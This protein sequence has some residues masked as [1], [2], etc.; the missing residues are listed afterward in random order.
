MKIAQLIQ[1]LARTTFYALFLCC[2]GTSPGQ[3]TVIFHNTGGGQPLISEVRSIFV[4]QGL[5]QPR[6][7]FDFGFGTDEVP[8]AG[9]FLDS[10]TVSLQDAA[11]R[12]SAIYLNADANG[13]SWAP[14]TPG[15]LFIDPLSLS[16][17]PLD[18]PALQPSTA[19]KI[20]FQVSAPIPSQFL[21]S[22]VN[23]FFDLFDN[24]DNKT[25]QGW[26]SGLS[27]VSVPEP[28]ACTLLLLG[29][30]LCWRG[31]RRKSR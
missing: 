11:Q 12:F 16:V 20:A 17:R 25:S 28:S 9:T 29:G 13:V 10:F 1:A 7:V 2:R 4:D 5:Q 8:A 15:N 26:F 21:G 27:V 14:A 30:A 3:G 23:V 24:L 19:S 31:K 22:S 18:Y 6:L